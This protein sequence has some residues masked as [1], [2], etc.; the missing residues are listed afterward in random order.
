MALSAPFF[1]SAERFRELVPTPAPD[2]G[3]VHQIH[4]SDLTT[5][6]AILYD[7]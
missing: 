7:P 2:D 1:L 5:T 6:L 4:H 3:K